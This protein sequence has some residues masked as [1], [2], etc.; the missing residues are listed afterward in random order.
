MIQLNS[1]HYTLKKTTA[2]TVISKRTE[3]C[4]CLPTLFNRLV[5]VYF[6]LS[7]ILLSVCITTLSHGAK[8]ARL[9]AIPFT[10][11]QKIRKPAGSRPLKIVLWLMKFNQEFITKSN[12]QGWM[13][14]L[15]TDLWIR[16]VQRDWLSQFI[17][18]RMR[19]AR[20]G[21]PIKQKATLLIFILI[22]VNY[23]KSFSGAI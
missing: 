3:M 12:R 10:C 7:L 2:Q 18:Y 8:K 23:S 9:P 1:K 5:I 22:K 14:I 4:G 13:V 16:F 21:V 17:L 6:I 15:K 19:T 11:I 20:T